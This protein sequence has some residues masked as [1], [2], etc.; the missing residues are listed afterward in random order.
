MHTNPTVDMDAIQED[1][2]GQFLARITGHSDALRSQPWQG[3]LA[4]AAHCDNRLIRIPTGFGKTLGA[5]SA[6]AWQRVRNDNQAWPRR[7][8]WC[9][10]TRVLVEQTELEIRLALARLELLWDEAGD[11]DGKV[12][13]HVIMGGHNSSPWHRY[14][15]REAVLIGTQDMLLSR[16]MNRG[17]ASPRARWPMEFGLLSQDA[18]WV[19][20]EVQLMDVGLATSAQLQAFRDDDRSANKTM[21]PCFTWWMSA[22]LQ[23][24]WLEKSPDTT[25]LFED[26]A[27]HDIPTGARN[28]A[29]WDGVAK[30]LKVAR[31]DSSSDLAREVSRRHRD[32]NCG[33]RGPTLVV[34]N[35]VR[36]AVEVW[37]ALRADPGLKGKQVDIRLAHSRFRPAERASWHLDFLNRAACDPGANRIIVSTQVIEAGVDISA[38]LLVTELAPWASLVQRF[39]RCARWGGRGEV[40][41]ADFGHDSDKKAAPYS[42]EEIGTARD[43]CNALSDVAP[44]HLERFEEENRSLLPR[45]Y[46]YDPLHLL[47]RH[48]LDDLFDTSADLSGADVD[49]SRF[50]RSGNERDVQV[51]WADVAGDDPS[52]SVR[53]TREELCAVPFL[54]VRNWLCQPKSEKR[55]AGVRAWVWDWLDRGW[56]LLATRDVYPGQTVL[57]EAS[58]G[59]YGQEQGWAPSSKKPVELLRRGEQAH[60]VIKPCWRR[61]QESWRVGERRVRALL[62]EDQ[63]DAAEEDESLSIVGDDGW[64]TIATHGRLVG[65]EVERIATWLAPGLAGLLHLASRWHDLGKAHPAFQNS[66]QAEDR[67]ERDDIA[68]APDAAWPCD[69]RDMYRIGFEDQR[70]GFRHE[71]ASALGLFGVLQRHQ[72]RHEALLGPWQ[73]WLEAVGET[74]AGECFQDSANTAP[75][76]AIEQEILGL[77]ADDFD[78]LAYLVCAHHGKLRLAWHASPADQQAN[79]QT[80]RIRGVRQGDVLPP[81]HLAGADGECHQLPATVLDLA[82]SEAGLNPR[83]G[84]SWTERVLNLVERLGPFTLAWL[85]A[86]LRAADQRMSDPSTRQQIAD[87]LLQHQEK[88]HARQ[89]MAGS[90]EA[91][92]QPAARRASPPPFGGDSPP[93]GELHG[94]GGRTR[95]RG[96]DSAKTRTPH[97]ATRYVETAVGIL[98]Y[99]ELAPLLAER[100]GNTEVAIVNRTLPDATIHDLLL[101]IHRRI[102]ADLTPDIA[103]RW[104]L[105]DVRVS[106]HRP[107]PYWQVSV[108]MRNYASDLDARLAAWDNDPERSIETLTFAEGRLLE[109][110]PF[111]DFNGRATRLLLTELM[112]RLDLPAIDPAASSAEMPHYMA[113][114]RAYD[115]HDPRPLAVIWRHRLSQGRSP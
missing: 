82:P 38:A 22:T 88:Q 72:P 75:P 44:V 18:L 106:D 36:R 57:V 7:L 1:E 19:M 13:V 29:L 14:P 78:L 99:Q 54:D 49:I 4:K 10:P 51:F 5:L 89:P 102:C 105:R 31:L 90:S 104:R 107:P 69:L 101:E 81:V 91:V 58:V 41:V 87:P 15:E 52:T 92:A 28:G 83:T 79:D 97:S 24:G 110:H 3:Q 85:E 86:L 11:H 77:N 56:R 42:L 71:L 70:R 111:E 84:R 23:R 108:L 64:Q 67:P 32:G 63:A 33:G 109:I 76:T 40:V 30:P 103:G 59:G 21:R 55:K 35:T 65:E 68:K 12:G 93:C 74:R 95:G 39:G 61:S 60:Y 34:L 45:L 115:H 9:L 37:K 47:L 16:A 26:L 50:I 62:P 27:Q 2:F 100:V 6:W 96:V 20:D 46:P 25:R 112:C 17:Y 43:A 113:A 98:S 8:V 114:L 73:D 66:I 53:P 80:L 94:N 48:E